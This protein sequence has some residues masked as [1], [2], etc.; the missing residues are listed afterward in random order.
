MGVRG[1]GC[2]S[3]IELSYKLSLQI[4]WKTLNQVLT[5]CDYVRIELTQKCYVSGHYGYT[6]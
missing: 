6:T 3:N 2:K 4:S 1:K 5:K